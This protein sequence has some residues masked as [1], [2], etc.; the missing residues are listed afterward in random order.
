MGLSE[1]KKQEINRM[2]AIVII[3][4]R[5]NGVGLTNYVRAQEGLNFSLSHRIL[6]VESSDHLGLKSST[7]H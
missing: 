3:E 5:T 2:F 4:S 6:Q 7:T 1:F